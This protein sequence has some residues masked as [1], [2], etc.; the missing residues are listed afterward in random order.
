MHSKGN[1]HQNEKA[2]YKMGGQHLHVTDKG[3]NKKQP[4][5]K[6]GADLN[7]HFSKE[8]IQ[9]ANK[10]VNRCSKSL[11][12]REIQIKTTMR[13]HCTPV[14]VAMI[15]KSKLTDAGEGVGERETSCTL[16]GNWCSR[17]GEQQRG[18]LTKTRTSV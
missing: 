4:N 9:M 6:K 7:R 8:D 14:R 3:N 13:Y 10:H 16:G 18:S 1:H 2:T 17:S 5:Q 12:I 11:I 15:K